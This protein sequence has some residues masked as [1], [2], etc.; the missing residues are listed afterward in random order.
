MTELSA[1]DIDE[2]LW[3][4]FSNY[5]YRLSNIYIFGSESDFFAISKSGYVVEV[6]VK[7]SRSDFKNDFKKTTSNG[8]NKHEYLSSDSTFKPNQFYFAVPS[9]LI[10]PNEI[11]K[12]YGLIYYSGFSAQI[13]KRSKYLHKEKLMNNIVFVKRLLSKFYWRYTDLKKA[14]MIKGWDL[15]NQRNADNLFE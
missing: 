12:E 11:P 10:K 7:I 15:K 4:A 13:V 9:G 3:V 8:K 1:Q 6:E 14:V 2:A 5:D